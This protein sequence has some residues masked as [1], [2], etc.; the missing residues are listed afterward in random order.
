MNLNKVVNLLKEIVDD[1]PDFDGSD[2]VV[3]ISK[4]EH[5]IVKGYS[6]HIT[7]NFNNKKKEYISK[8]ALAKNLAIHQESNSVMLY[9][10][11]PQ[12]ER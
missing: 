1:Q 10:A 8:L 3:G 5:S 12:C 6:L 2:F 7:G 11:K 9:E 4:A